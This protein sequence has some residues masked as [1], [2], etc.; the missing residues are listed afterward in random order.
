MPLTVADHKDLTPRERRPTKLSRWALSNQK[1]LKL[2]YQ[3][4]FEVE[5][6]PE[7]RKLSLPD[8]VIRAQE[9]LDEYIAYYKDNGTWKEDHG[10]PEDYIITERDV[11]YFNFRLLRQA[12][13]LRSALLITTLDWIESLKFQDLIVKMVEVAEEKLAKGSIDEVVKVLRQINTARKDFEHF[14]RLDTDDKLRRENAAIKK[15]LSRLNEQLAWWESEYGQKQIGD[16]KGT[17]VVD[18]KVI[19][20]KIDDSSA[21]LQEMEELTRE[22]EPEQ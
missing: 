20:V 10:V 13:A 5:S 9:V 7:W 4:I 12:P 16:G 2:K 1:R 17:A 22:E 21:K 11:N 15:A 18:D 6:H 19:T 8:K 3:A 14:L